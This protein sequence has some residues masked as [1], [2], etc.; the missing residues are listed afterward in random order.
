MP[1]SASCSFCHKAF[2]TGRSL[3]NHL[4]SRHPQARQD[5]FT[6]R[7]DKG[8]VFEGPEPRDLP[9]EKCDDYLKWLSVLVE[10][11]NGSLI[12]DYPGKLLLKINFLFQGS[13][14]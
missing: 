10:R 5:V 4:A 9:E 13:M 3:S 7:D 1:Y 6:F 12:P 14:L 2:K 11:V 8:T